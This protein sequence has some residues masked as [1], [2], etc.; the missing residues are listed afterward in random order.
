VTQGMT[1]TLAARLAG[2]AP[3]W[4]RMACAS[5]APGTTPGGLPRCTA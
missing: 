2:R 1:S 4:L 3:P 5:P